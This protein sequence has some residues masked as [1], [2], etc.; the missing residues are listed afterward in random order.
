MEKSTYTYLYE[1]GCLIINKGEEVIHIEYI[2]EF[3]QVEDKICEL[4][5]EGVI[6]SL[7]ITRTYSR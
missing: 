2:D 3:D 1:D 5:E 4:Q 7:E 6:T